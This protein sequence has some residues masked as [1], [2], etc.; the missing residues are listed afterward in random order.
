MLWQR[1][2]KRCLHK[3]G[4]LH[5]VEDGDLIDESLAR[6]LIHDLVLLQ[7]LHRHRFLRVPLDREHHLAERALPDGFDEGV[8]ADR[9]HVGGEVPCGGRRGGYGGGRGVAPRLR[10]AEKRG[11]HSPS[12]GDEHKLNRWDAITWS[13][14]SYGTDDMMD[15]DLLMMT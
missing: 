6:I 1:C 12:V 8:V 14:G 4:V 11:G 10:P 13:T 9:L 7:D 2:R 15:F 3:V 5:A